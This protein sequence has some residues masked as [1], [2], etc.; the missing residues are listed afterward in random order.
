VRA[1]RRA[2]RTESAH[3]SA[4]IAATTAAQ[5]TTGNAV[6]GTAPRWAAYAFQATSRGRTSGTARESG[7]K[8]DVAECHVWT[9]NEGRVSKME[10]FI[11]AGAM[12]DALR[13]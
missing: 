6:S 3:A 12:L 10:F 5:A 9:V 13:S 4:S 2:G 1:S 11:D 7:K 8:F